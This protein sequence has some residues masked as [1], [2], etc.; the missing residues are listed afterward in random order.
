MILIMQI[1]GRIEQDYRPECRQNRLRFDPGRVY[2]LGMFRA[3][4]FFFKLSCGPRL[5]A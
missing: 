1:Y 3:Q 2:G 5:G 4:P